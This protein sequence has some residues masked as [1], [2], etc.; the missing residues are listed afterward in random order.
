MNG[1]RNTYIYCNAIKYN[2][3]FVKENITPF[4]KEKEILFLPLTEFM[5]EKFSF[6]QK[7]IYK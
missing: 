3:D 6:I 4:A 5:A 7:K 1:E 2:I